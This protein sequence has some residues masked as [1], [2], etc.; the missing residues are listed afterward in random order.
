MKRYALPVV[1]VILAA[2]FAYGFRYKTVSAETRSYYTRVILWDRLRQRTC[3]HEVIREHREP[4]P[5][6]FGVIDR[7]PRYRTVTASSTFRCF[8][9]GV[10]GWEIVLIILGAA[11]AVIG[12][13]VKQDLGARVVDRRRR[14]AHEKDVQERFEEVHSAM[15]ELI[16]EIRRDLQNPKLQSN[17]DLYVVPNSSGTI[18]VGGKRRELVYYEDRHENLLANVKRLENNEFVSDSTIGQTPRYRMTEEFAR[19]VLH[20]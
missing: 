10:V 7:P 6:A 2:A 15:P 19:L 16:E 14:R 3:E 17:R 8:D 5:N 4:I 9:N 18:K 11:L 1:L 12:A 13:V 20:G